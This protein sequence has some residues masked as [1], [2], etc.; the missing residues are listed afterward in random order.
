MTR[1]SNPIQQP[2][3][4]FSNITAQARNRKDHIRITRHTRIDRACKIKIRRIKDL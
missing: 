4:A 3:R 2:K 1:D